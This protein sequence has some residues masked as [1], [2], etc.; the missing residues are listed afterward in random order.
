M[1]TLQRLVWSICLLGKGSFIWD[2]PKRNRFS[3][4]NKDKRNIRCDFLVFQRET[5]V[6]L[7]VLLSLSLKMTEMLSNQLP[8]KGQEEAFRQQLVFYA[9]MAIC[10]RLHSGGVL[11]AAKQNLRT[12]FL[13]KAKAAKAMCSRISSARHG[14]RWWFSD[15]R[16]ETVDPSRLQW[17][18]CRT[19]QLA[20]V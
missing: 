20:R 5:Q 4:N 7:Q 14:G 19:H 6:Q 1:H 12:R 3:P 11:F 8:T 15:P 2:L 13:R 18:H 9:W 17:P 10:A 16:T